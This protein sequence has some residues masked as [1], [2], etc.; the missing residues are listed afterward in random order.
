M[1]LH[2]PRVLYYTKTPDHRCADEPYSTLK[3]DAPL[4]SE[5]WC[6]VCGRFWRMSPHLPYVGTRAWEVMDRMTREEA[7]ELDL[8]MN[9]PETSP[10]FQIYESELGR[11]SFP[12]PPQDPTF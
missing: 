5:W 10:D 6:P 8:L 9:G 3:L 12:A 11:K 4:Y 1:T 2:L 7:L